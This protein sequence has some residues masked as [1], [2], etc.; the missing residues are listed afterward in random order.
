MRDGEI[1]QLFYS[2]TRMR[3]SLSSPPIETMDEGEKDHSRTPFASIQLSVTIM[4]VHWDPSGSILNKWSFRHGSKW[5]ELMII[6][7]WSVSSLQHFLS[8]Q[9]LFTISLVRI[10]LWS[11]CS[12]LR[13]DGS[14]SS[15]FPSRKK[16]EKEWQFYSDPCERNDQQRSLSVL[17]PVLRPTHVQQS[18]HV[19]VQEH[20]VL[21]VHL[22]HA[23][24]I[25]RI[26]SRWVKHHQ[27]VPDV[28]F[29][30]I[31]AQQCPL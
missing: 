10:F 2:L 21:L 25:P 12:R 18:P 5:K 7:E 3:T 13:G 22:A 28:W 24:C 14:T 11:M 27:P 31:W 9:F 29:S 16:I 4:V 8:R 26:P 17:I 19:I 30:S 20:W 1:H 6:D 15:V 23:F